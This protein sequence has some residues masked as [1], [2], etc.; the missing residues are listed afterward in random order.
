VSLVENENLVAITSRRISSSLTEFA[1]VV[2]TI[3]RSGINLNY[4]KRTATVTRQ[5]NA[6]IAFAARSIGRALGAVQA[7]SKDAR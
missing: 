3:V 2:N 1:G 4:V 5:L 6:G 7:A